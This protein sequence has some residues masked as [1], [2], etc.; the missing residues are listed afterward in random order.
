MDF[1]IIFFHYITSLSPNLKLHFVC[2][3]YHCPYQIKFHLTRKKRE[4]HDQNTFLIQ[5]WSGDLSQYH[6]IIF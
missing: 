2:Y 1:T 3:N 4:R 5:K 6:F